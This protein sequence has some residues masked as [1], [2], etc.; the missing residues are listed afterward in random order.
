MFQFRLQ[1]VMDEYVAG[2]GTWYQPMEK[3]LRFA[4]KK[5]EMLREDSLKMRAKDCT[6]CFAHG[7]ITIV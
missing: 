2:V 5:L 7:R 6:N 4:E 1:K 3:C